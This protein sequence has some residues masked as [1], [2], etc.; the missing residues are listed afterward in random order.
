MAIDDDISM[1]G[2]QLTETLDQENEWSRLK[3]KVSKVLSGMCDI[4]FFIITI[5][6]HVNLK[7]LY[8][9]SQKPAPT[10]LFSCPLLTFVHQPMA[11][12]CSKNLLVKL[13]LV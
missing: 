4:I 3:K 11:C 7:Q 8:P 12:G 1:H 9:I 5:Y 2:K 10:Q 13:Y 6:I